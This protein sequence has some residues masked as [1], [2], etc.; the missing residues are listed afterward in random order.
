MSKS[1]CDSQDDV[2]EQPYKSL[3]I[4][5]S[6]C[7][8]IIKKSDIVRPNGSFCDLWKL[9]LLEKK[10]NGKQFLLLTMTYGQAS[11]NNKKPTC[12]SKVTFDVDEILKIEAGGAIQVV[13]QQ[14]YPDGN[15][16]AVDLT[17]TSLWD[18]LA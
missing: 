16:D 8:K 9:Y 6:A 5:S 4:I 2:R 14:A 13:L 1:F 11:A 3:A 17:E 12:P 10:D 15:G 7:G 18:C